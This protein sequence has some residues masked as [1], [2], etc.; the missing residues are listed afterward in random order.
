MRFLFLILVTM[1]LT[2]KQLVLCMVFFTR[3]M[4]LLAS[5]KVGISGYSLSVTG[6]SS[7]SIWLSL[8]LPLRTVVSSHTL[9][10][11]AAICSSKSTRLLISIES[12]L[13]LLRISMIVS[14]LSL[15]LVIIV[16]LLL[17][18]QSIS[19]SVRTSL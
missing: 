7:T 13:M 17:W 6:I 15:N 19:Q 8:L 3:R 18:F 1:N 16:F 10:L 9:V 5:L 2:W 12:T 4:Y 11:I 14:R